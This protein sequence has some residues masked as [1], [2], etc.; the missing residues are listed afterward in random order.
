LH[1]DRNDGLWPTVVTDEHGVALGLVWSSAQ[2]L[3]QAIESRRG[4]YQS[5]SRGIWVKGETSGSTETLIGVAVD[6]DRDTL[7]FTVRQTGQFCHE[8]TRTCWGE[9]HGVGRLGRR[10]VSL[11]E[12]M[13]A[14]SNTTRLLGDPALLDAKLGE[15]VAELVAPDADVAAETA[16]VLYFALVKSIA[17]G[18]TVEDVVEILDRRER[19]VSRRAMIVK[20]VE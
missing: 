16:D 15:E 9:D 10:L 17:A 14:G 5:R 12:E 19:R 20:E 11:A 7:R 13:P 4:V 2:S 3:G 1:S 8:G 6:S 18:V